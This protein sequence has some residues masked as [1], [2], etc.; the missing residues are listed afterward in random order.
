MYFNF[1]IFFSFF[2]ICV[3][4]NNIET[5]QT[6]LLDF[7]S[8]LSRKLN[9]EEIEPMFDD[10]FRHVRSSLNKMVEIITEKM[11]SDIQEAL[12]YV[13]NKQEG[14]PLQEETVGRLDPLF[15]YLNTQLDLLSE[16]LYGNIFQKV[17]KQAF[18]LLIKDLEAIVV[19]FD[20]KDKYHRYETVKL[21]EASLKVSFS[22]FSCFL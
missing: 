4:L 22:F 21:I 10:C 17:L 2:S 7:S 18:M 3:R 5:C 16:Y 11:N 1:L 8:Y 6:L 14:T 20:L 13:V 9:A 19:P 12:K 15:S